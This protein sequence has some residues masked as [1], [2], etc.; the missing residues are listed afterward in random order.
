MSVPPWITNDVPAGAQAVWLR[1]EGR[2]D[3]L[4]FGDTRD[5]SADATSNVNK[6][7]LYLVLPDPPNAY[8]LPFT[9]EKQLPSREVGSVDA[10]ST[11]TRLVTQTCRVNISFIALSKTNPQTEKTATTSRKRTPNGHTYVERSFCGTVYKST[12]SRKRLRRG[13]LR[14]QN[15]ISLAFQ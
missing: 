9:L 6:S 2:D 4:D 14:T 11:G 1:P 12:S 5:H 8:N 3:S 13:L 15:F 10:V 7:S